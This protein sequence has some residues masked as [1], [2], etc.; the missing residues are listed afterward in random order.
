MCGEMPA[1]LTWSADSGPD[2]P[3]R[4]PRHPGLGSSRTTAECP[5]SLPKGESLTTRNDTAV[6]SLRT[7]TSLARFPPN[8]NRS[9]WL[10]ACPAPVRP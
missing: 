5:P 6:D 8:P 9:G 10:A 2:T 4:N 7:N 1:G 3:P